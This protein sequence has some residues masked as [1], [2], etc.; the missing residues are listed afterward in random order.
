MLKKKK[1]IEGGTTNSVMNFAPQVVWKMIDCK[2]LDFLFWNNFKCI[3]ELH[4]S[5]RE[6]LHTLHNVS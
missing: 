1:K 3:E 6:F 4:R 5:Y 2:K